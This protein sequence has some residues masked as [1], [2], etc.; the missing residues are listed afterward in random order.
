MMFSKRSFVRLSDAELANYSTNGLLDADVDEYKAYLL[1]KNVYEKAK[2]ELVAYKKSLSSCN[3]DEAI[4]NGSWLFV[5]GIIYDILSN[6]TWYAKRDLSVTELSRIVEKDNLLEYLAADLIATPSPLLRINEGRLRSAAQ[7]GRECKDVK[8]ITKDSFK[9]L[10]IDNWHQF[11]KE[12]FSHRPDYILKYYTKYFVRK[13]ACIALL[14]PKEYI[15]RDFT[16]DEMI[17]LAYGVGDPFS[18]VGLIDMSVPTD[19]LLA[20]AAGKATV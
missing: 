17:G 4:E 7:I 8:P 13:N 15:G 3:H 12:F 2:R 20:L 9:D 18:Y 16:Q 14:R 1:Y 5:M 10:M 11:E 19:I 6:L